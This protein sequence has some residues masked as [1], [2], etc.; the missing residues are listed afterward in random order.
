MISFFWKV[1]SAGILG[2]GRAFLVATDTMQF[3]KDFPARGSRVQN[4]TQKALK[5]GLQIKD[6]MTTVEALS[7]TLEGFL[8]NPGSENPTQLPDG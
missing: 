6:P 1:L 4:L 2:G 7:R 3:L 8:G 5:S